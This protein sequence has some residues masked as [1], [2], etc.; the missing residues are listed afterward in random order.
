M[1][2]LVGAKQEK[3]GALVHQISERQIKDLITRTVQST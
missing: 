1:T 2:K 3:P